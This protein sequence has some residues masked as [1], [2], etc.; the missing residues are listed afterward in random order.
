MPD[1]KSEH[2]KALK[3]YLKAKNIEFVEKDVEAKREDLAELLEVSNKFAGVPFTII[4]KDDGTQVKLKGFNKEEF[5]KAFGDKGEPVVKADS[6]VSS[7][8]PAPAVS[9]AKPI[10]PAGSKDAEQSA[11]PDDAQK[12]LDELMGSLSQKGGAGAPS[13]SGVSG[14]H[15]AGTASESA[16]TPVQSAVPES[17]APAPQATQPQ[18]SVPPAPSNPTSSQS[19]PPSDL[20]KVPNFAKK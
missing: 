3:D 16:N 20:P 6:A 7:E 17:T 12:K 11:Q 9:V 15:G 13:A 19:Q 2:C 5:D 1:A 10:S 8:A 4:E 14:A 18:S